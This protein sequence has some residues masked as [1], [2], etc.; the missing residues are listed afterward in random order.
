M[1]WRDTRV[2][3]PDSTSLPAYRNVLSEETVQAWPHPDGSWLRM[4]EL[5]GSFPVALLTRTGSVPSDSASG[6]P[7]SG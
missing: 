3:C 7:A 4:A 6:Q 1:I 5:L 2:R